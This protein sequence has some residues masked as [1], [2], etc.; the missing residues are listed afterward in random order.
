MIFKL[1]K[2]QDNKLKSC[3]SP[4]FNKIYNFKVNKTHNKQLEII[5]H[6]KQNQKSQNK[7]MIYYLRNNKIQILKIRTSKKK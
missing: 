6:N 7:K 4:A 1:F 3:Y 5:A 2:G